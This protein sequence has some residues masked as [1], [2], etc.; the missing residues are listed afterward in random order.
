ME[1][2]SRISYRPDTLVSDLEAITSLEVEVY[3]SETD[4]PPF[5]QAVSCSSDLLAGEIRY[6]TSEPVGQ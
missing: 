4:E 1:G 2:G 6:Y 5:E 3:T